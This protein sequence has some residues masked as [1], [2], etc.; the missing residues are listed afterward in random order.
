[1]AVHDAYILRFAH[2][3]LASTTHLLTAIFHRLKMYG[4]FRSHIHLLHIRDTIVCKCLYVTLQRDPEKGGGA[5]PSTTSSHKRKRQVST[6][7]T[8]SQ[9]KCKGSPSK[10][11]LSFDDSDEEAEPA[12]PSGA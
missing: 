8:T 1:M 12:K 3:T 5:G 9:P 11:L 4:L 7:G 6:N 10:Q 2:N